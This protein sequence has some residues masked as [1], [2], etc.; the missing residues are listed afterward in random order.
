MRF[1]IGLISLPRS[2]LFSSHLLGMYL[3]FFSSFS[4]YLSTFSF[5]IFFLLF[6]FFEFFVTLLTCFLWGLTQWFYYLFLSLKF[7]FLTFHNSIFCFPRLILGNGVFVRVSLKD[8]KFS[9]FVIIASCCRV[10]CVVG[11]ES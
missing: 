1:W 10:F 6:F 8:L 3:F 2:H 7:V 9:G 4:L 5:S 11:S